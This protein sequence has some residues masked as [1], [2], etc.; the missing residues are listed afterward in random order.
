MGIIII[1]FVYED[2]AEGWELLL[3]II[4]VYEDRAEG[5]E[6]LLYIIFVYEVSAECWGLLLLN[7]STRT[8]LKVGDYYD[9][10]NYNYTII[11]GTV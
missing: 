4:F 1:I 3:Y 10:Y 9:N 2:R 6:L 11:A 7:S 8:A 5:W